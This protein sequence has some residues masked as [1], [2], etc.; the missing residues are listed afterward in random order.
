LTHFRGAPTGTPRW[1]PDGKLIAFDSRANGV[2]Q[3]YV[4][5]AEG[6]EPRQVTTDAMGGQV[7]AWSR[8]GE[9]I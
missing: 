9:W 6:G 4:I 2:A 7:P 1:S 8:D 5:P 3:I